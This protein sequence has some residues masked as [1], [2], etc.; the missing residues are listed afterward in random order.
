MKIGEIASY[1][2]DLECIL[3]LILSTT[4]VVVFVV[5]PVGGLGAQDLPLKQGF[6]FC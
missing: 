3:I 1:L 5:N 6:P 4:V 2:P